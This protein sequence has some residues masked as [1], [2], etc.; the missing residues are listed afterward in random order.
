MVRSLLQVRTWKF[1]AVISRAGHDGKRPTPFF[2]K[3][4]LFN[5]RD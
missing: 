2:K 5:R 4:G 3:Q 1:G